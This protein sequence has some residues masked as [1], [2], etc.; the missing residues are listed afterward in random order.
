MQYI[1]VALQINQWPA[2]SEYLRIVG[3]NVR[4]SKADWELAH[5][6]QHGTDNR[7]YPVTY[8]KRYQVKVPAWLHEHYLQFV[9]NT[10]GSCVEQAADVI[11]DTDRLNFMLVK[12]RHVV[13]EQLPWGTHEV[14]V[15][16]GFMGDKRYR[17]VTV[18]GEL[19]N[20][21]TDA[22]QSIKRQAI[23]LAINEQ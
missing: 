6:N 8:N 17:S 7:F 20:H 2:F 3:I 12:H 11:T 4:E 16:E 21:D 9:R 13:I 18:K 23:D 5:V 1:A 22:A 19:P 10:Q 15:E 14:Y